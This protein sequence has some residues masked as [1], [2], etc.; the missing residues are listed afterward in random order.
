MMRASGICWGEE[1]FQPERLRLRVCP[2]GEGIAAEAVDSLDTKVRLRLV[3]PTNRGDH[4]QRI[5]RRGLLDG[6]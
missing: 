4:N 1:I 2:Y 3:K 5:F 6:R